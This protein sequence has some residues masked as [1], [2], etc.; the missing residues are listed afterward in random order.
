MS[1]LITHSFSEISFY[2]VTP[3]YVS[4]NGLLIIC[5]LRG[6]NLWL[7]RAKRKQATYHSRKLLAM[8]KTK[9]QF[10][11]QLQITHAETLYYFVYNYVICSAAE[12]CFLDMM[13]IYRATSLVF[14]HLICQEGRPG[15]GLAAVSGTL[16]SYRTIV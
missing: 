15:Q 1:I 4:E 7:G 11:H 12:R 5:T 3:Y 16:F 6:S 8:Q 13:L 10:P 14:K 2:S 9:V